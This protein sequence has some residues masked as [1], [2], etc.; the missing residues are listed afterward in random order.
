LT[1]GATSELA[2]KPFLDWI[3]PRDRTI[4]QAVLENNEKSFFARHIT[5]DGN[6]LQLQIQLAEHEEGVFVFGRCAKAP[7][8]LESDLARS[9]DATVSGTLDAIARII[10]DLNPGYKCSILLVAD[11]RFVFGAG[12]SL[13]AD[14][15]AAVHGYAIGPTVGSCGTAIFWNIPVM[16]E[17][18]QADPLWSSLAPLAKKAG[19]AAC[20]SH[21]FVSSNGKVLGALALYSPEPRTPT[22]EQ[23][24]LLKAAARIT[25]LAVERGRAEEALKRSDET[26]KVA[27]NQLQATL[28]ALPDLLF[29]VD[30][31]GRIF[32]YHSHRD[33]LLPVPPEAFIGKRFADVLPPEAADAC[34]RAIDEAAEKG[35][36]YGV[37]SRLSLPQGEHWFELSVAPVH[38]DAKTSQRFIMISR[39]ITERTRAEEKINYMAYFD[40]LTELPNRTL[41][42]DRLK[43]AMASS[44]RSG[45]YGALLF[46]DLDHFKTLNDTLG[47]DIGDLL[48]KQVARRLIGCVREEDTVARFGGDEFVVMLVSLSESQSEAASVVELI[49]E[50]INE[51]LN[52]PY[53]LNDIPYHI[54]PSIGASVFL[55][56]HP[57]ID[58]LLKQADLAMYKAK[59]AGRNTL[60]FFDPGMVCDIQKRVSL[61]KEL[62]EAVQKQ[63]FVLYYQ[64]QMAGGQVT[65]AEA[66]L[67]WQHPERGLVFPGEFI[68]MI[69][70][71]GLIRPV[72]QWVLDIACKQLADWARQPDMSHLTVS[73]NISAH[74]LNHNDFVD[75]VLTALE[76]SGANPERLKLEL[77]ESLLVN[78]VEEII[79]K[80]TALKE[81]GVGFSL[82]DFGTGYSS[83]SYLKR[84]PLDQL[85][86]DQS[87]VRDILTDPNDA[88]IAKMIVALAD[89]LGLTVIAEGVETEAQREALAQEGCHAYQGYLFSRPVPIADLESYVRRV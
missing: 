78:N 25:G 70:E 62:S 35:V 68:S 21:P 45:R 69:E 57:D 5:R 50:K 41:L 20:W 74:Q 88:I 48:L 60:R 61:D 73:V 44:Q 51:A 23:L 47:H 63:Q 43:Q 79:G 77:T 76:C 84:L 18:I 59:N 29:E 81:K 22:A 39:D 52:Q 55:G 75:Q 26:I 17:D 2:E 37:T 65:G 16:V 28:N 3:D 34:Q 40:Q 38:A 9:A 67:R 49:G 24:N 15:N 58:T 7:T 87:F 19:V 83:L 4:V 82:D 56:P 42:M 80:M 11:G 54:T 85:K 36:S 8:Q 64:V 32:S 53:D 12:P 33:D 89:S 72:G 46:L 14:Y 27:N 86:I 31:E 71:T 30:P 66:L 13:P 1:Q 6:A 10:E